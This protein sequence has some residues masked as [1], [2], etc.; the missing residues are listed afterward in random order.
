MRRTA[1]SRRPQGSLA[2]YGLLDALCMAAC[3]SSSG[4][5]LPPASTEHVGTVASPLTY[6]QLHVF[7][8]SATDGA[9]PVRASPLLLGGVLYGMT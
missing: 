5:D 8:G 2:H 3:S 7:S 9:S 4:G 6:A 1:M